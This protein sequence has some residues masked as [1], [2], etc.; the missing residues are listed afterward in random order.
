MIAILWIFP[1]AVL[2]T[3]C[4]PLSHRCDVMVYC[5]HHVGYVFCVSSILCIFFLSLLNPPWSSCCK[6][7]LV[8]LS[9][10]R[11]YLSWKISVSPSLLKDSFAEY[12][13]FDWQLFSFTTG[14]MTFCTLFACGAFAEQSQSNGAAIKCDL[15]LWRFHGSF[16]LCTWMFIDLLLLLLSWELTQ[17]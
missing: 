9:F 4:F 8:V 12:S 16:L 7:G 2:S 11:F 10:L 15:A 1:L 14:N 13:N 17:G 6:V 5:I 3:F